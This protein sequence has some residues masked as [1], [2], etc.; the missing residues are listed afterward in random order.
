MGSQGNLSSIGA[1]SGRRREN[2]QGQV[3]RTRLRVFGERLERGWGKCSSKPTSVVDHKVDHKVGDGRSGMGYPITL[4][5]R[6][7][8]GSRSFVRLF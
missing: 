5:A 7:Q 1:G 3:R 4:V 6:L 2:T 8:P